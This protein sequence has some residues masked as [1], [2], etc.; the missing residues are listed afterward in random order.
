LENEWSIQ[1]GRIFI[2][3]WNKC[4][5]ALENWPAWMI[6]VND[7]MCHA[8]F[9]FDCTRKSDMRKYN[10]H[11]SKWHEHWPLLFSFEN[12]RQN[13]VAVTSM[14]S[15]YISLSLFVFKAFPWYL[16]KQKCNNCVNYLLIKIIVS[17]EY[18]I[19]K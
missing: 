9:R 19:R 12:Q 8:L 14:A 2:I 6:S 7:I 13:V 17:D 4:H 16:V 1:Y 18:K 15:L 11:Y 5:K 10:R 3:T